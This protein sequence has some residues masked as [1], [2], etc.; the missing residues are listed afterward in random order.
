MKV[1]VGD[2]LHKIKVKE[3]T[4]NSLKDGLV[5]RLAVSKDQI[6]LF[7]SNGQEITTDHQFS[8]LLKVSRE[9]NR[10]P[11]VICTITN[12]ASNITTVFCQEASFQV[13]TFVSV[14]D[15]FMA[16]HEMTDNKVLEEEDKKADEK[17]M[18][19]PVKKS[20]IDKK[21]KG[22]SECPVTKAFKA[23]HKKVLAANSDL[24]QSPELLAFLIDSCKSKIVKTIIKQ[25]QEEVAL[26]TLPELLE[27]FKKEPKKEEK[28][29]TDVKKV[30]RSKE[31]EAKPSLKK[32][33]LKKNSQTIES[34][35]TE[36]DSEF[37]T[38]P[39]TM[40]TSLEIQKAEPLPK[41]TLKKQ[42]KKAANSSTQKSKIVLGNE[43]LVLG[44]NLAKDDSFIDLLEEVREANPDLSLKNVTETSVLGESN[45]EKPLEE[46]TLLIKKDSLKPQEGIAHNKREQD[47]D[48]E[49][50]TLL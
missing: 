40:N 34:K 44:A 21:G 20:I 7:S 11:K 12:L 22:K 28:P 27:T 29:K 33:V 30:K 19:V 24:I 8:E 36:V 9:E 18:K 32:S 13:S 4:S 50:W 1:Q 3:P 23:V 25:F 37:V 39:L 15:E 45:A 41:K 5:Y 31:K 35:D 42:P 46:A 14:T 47:P 6:N 38:I 16:E 48:L 26:K 17:K 43:T 49:G 10:C 2:S